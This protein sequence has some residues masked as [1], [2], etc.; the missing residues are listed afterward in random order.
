MPMKK[1]LLV[2]L[3]VPAL[4]IGAMWGLASASSSHSVQTRPVVANSGVLAQAPTSPTTE[5][6]TAG[7]PADTGKDAGKGEAAG[8]TENAN[9]DKA[10]DPRDPPGADHQCPPDCRPGEA[11]D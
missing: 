10:G 9:D 2:L 3:F 4:V 1:R 11:K 6:P 7:D 8:E 5:A